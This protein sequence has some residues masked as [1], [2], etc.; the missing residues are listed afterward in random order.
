M[1]GC[2]P[3]RRRN[4]ESGQEWGWRI[5]DDIPLRSRLY[6]RPRPQQ[7]IAGVCGG[8]A[9]YFGIGAKWVRLVFLIAF[10][11]APLPVLIFYVILGFVLSVRPDDLY[12]SQQQEAFW[13]SVRR[14]PPRTVHS[15]RSK[16]RDLERRLRAA[17]AVVTSP[18]Y[19]MDQELKR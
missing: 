2:G 15:L 6:R 3:R 11:V 18:E 10:F 4:G 1:M 17:E 9:D 8:I 16:F 14:D 19:Q 7:K 13:Q 12:Q 5:R